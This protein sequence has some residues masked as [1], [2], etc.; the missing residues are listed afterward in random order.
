VQIIDLVET[1]REMGSDLTDL[2]L[3]SLSNRLNEIMRVL[4]VIS[5]I[6]MPLSFIVGVYGMNFNTDSPTN[7]PELN[8]RYGYVLVLAVLAATAGGMLWFFWRRGWLGKAPSP[9]ELL[10]QAEENGKK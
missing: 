4:T 1:Y 9:A 7:M 3:S 5:T 8:W 2:Y 6:F 10:K